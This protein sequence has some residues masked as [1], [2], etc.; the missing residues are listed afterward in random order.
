MD[1]TLQAPAKINL[2]LN[3]GKK[4]PDG[5]H[6]ID[7][8]FQMID[9]FDELRFREGNTG[10]ELVPIG[11]LA[12]SLVGENLVLKAAGLLKEASG[13]RSGALIHL[14]KRI[15]LGSGLGGGSSDAA[16]TLVGLNRLW[17]IGWPRERLLPLAGQLGSDVPF[18]LG[19][20]T[21]RVGGRGER[22][23]GVVLNE[24]LK[25]ILVFPGVS[26]GSAWAYAALDERFRLTK[27]GQQF[28]MERFANGDQRILTGLLRQTNDFEPVV[29]AAYPRI[30]QAME[31]LQRTG[32][33]LTRMSGSGSAV[34]GLFAEEAAGEKA[35]SALRREWGAENVWCCRSLKRSVFDKLL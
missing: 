3:V 19:P 13:T 11:P 12:G 27:E 2:F 23:E 4:R 15:P 8:L 25:I 17:G 34:F 24:I 31:A 14:E 32:A 28:S 7:S 35:A 6:E 10:I 22:V 16:A 18:F 20:P 33:V 30:A 9:L 1:L 21:A 5:Y 26:V 29:L